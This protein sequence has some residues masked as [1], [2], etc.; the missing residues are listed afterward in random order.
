MHTK[1]RDEIFES[2]KAMF[3]INIVAYAQI[4]LGYLNVKWKLET[5]QG[6][7]FV[8]KYSKTR[9]PEK[10]M[11]GLE[12]SLS[13]QAHLHANGIPS[14]KL[15]SYAGNYVL[16]TPSG[17]RFVLMSFCAGNMIKPGSAN[18]HQ[19][20]SLGN[21]TGSMHELLNANPA[22]GLQM[23]WH[24]WTKESLQASWTSRW[25]EAHSLQSEA[26]MAALDIQK[27]IIQETDISIF[28]QCEPGWCHWDLFVDNILFAPE[29]VAAILDFDRV[30]YVYP[31]F[32]IS[33]AILSCA[34]DGNELRIELVSAFVAGYRAHR[35]LSVEKLI[36]SIQLTWW[37]EAGWLE[38]DKAQDYAP[39]R[40]FRQENIWVGSNWGRLSEIFSGI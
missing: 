40:R 15:F 31:E 39:L 2:I 22:S 30:H 29:S 9:Y 27:K 6:K 28:S 16:S 21:I 8:K 10:L 26:T 36:R 19:M 32:D 18:E 24:I 20:H 23:H 33:R 25:S 4:E 35:S 3:N 38:V 12:I 1:A 7:L 5:D 37:K 11:K 17:A 14:P 34:L 13:H